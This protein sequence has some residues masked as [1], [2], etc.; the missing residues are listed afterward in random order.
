MAKNHHPLLVFIFVITLLHCSQSQSPESKGFRLKLDRRD[1]H[2]HPFPDTIR[3]PITRS[4]YLFTIDATIGTPATKKTFIFDTGSSLMWTQCKPCIRCFKQDY[5]LF[6]P[7]QSSSYQKLPPN[8]ALARFFKRSSNGSGD[9]LFNMTY[10]SGQS[11]S[12]IAAVETVTFAAPKNGRESIQGFVFGCT[13]NYQGDFSGNSLVTGI[14]GMNRSPLSLIGQMGAKAARRFSYCLPT[15]NSPIK[16]T[17]L[18]FGSDVN[19]KWGFQKTSFLNSGNDY[20]V[21][22]VDISVAGRR[23]NLPGGTFSKGCILDVGSAASML[24]MGAYTPVLNAVK[25]HLDRFNLTRVRSD[26]TSEGDLCYRLK[27]GFKNYTSMTLHFQGA[28]LEIGPDNLF[29]TISDRFC[30]A[31]FGSTRLTLLG[32]YQQQ[33]VKLVYDVGNQKLLFG[34]EDCSKDGA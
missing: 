17:F 6:D 20:S 25:Q 34:K 31:L 29:R 33:N 3:P 2:D 10:E 24:V 23:L 4:S 11:S 13:N 30:L 8:H 1:S 19:V 5:P 18:R 27:P 28:E 22:L 9:F 26:S 12:G 16:S 21:N 14:M 32:A 15:L 7:K